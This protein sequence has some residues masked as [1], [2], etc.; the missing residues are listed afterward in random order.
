[1]ISQRG[2][3]NQ[4]RLGFRYTGDEQPRSLQ[5]RRIHSVEAAKCVLR[6][7]RDWD[8]LKVTVDSVDFQ[9]AVES[10]NIKMAEDNVSCLA[11]LR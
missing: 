2:I 9:Q 6:G 10:G 5:Y 3:Q 7:Q 4:L 11:A 1:M 8:V